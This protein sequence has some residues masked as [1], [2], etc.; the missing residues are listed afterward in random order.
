MDKSIG[1][2]KWETTATFPEILEYDTTYLGYSLGNS[3]FKL[4]Y[5]MAMLSALVLSAGGKV[6]T[7]LIGDGALHAL[8]LWTEYQQEIADGKPIAHHTEARAHHESRSKGNYAVN[9]I[10]KALMLLGIPAQLVRIVRWDEA[11]KLAGD[12]YPKAYKV[13][14]DAYARGYKLL[15]RQASGEG[16]ACVRAQDM[17]E[18][19]TDPRDIEMAKQVELTL[20]QTRFTATPIGAAYLLLETAMML[21]HKGLHLGNGKVA[22]TMMYPCAK[23]A[24]HF[25]FAL[26]T[27][28]NYPELCTRPDAKMPQCIAGRCVN[29]TR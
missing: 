21:V 20:A 29:A 12:A 16:N 7:V 18:P 3:G 27:I 17:L 26:W 23:P 14:S 13:L 28:E 10:K 15:Q 2:Q 11:E 5:L 25:M 24:P 9:N 19:D 4:P 22:R 6:A 8:H 1:P